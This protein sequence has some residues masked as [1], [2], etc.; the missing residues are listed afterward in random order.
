M[1]HPGREQ[2]RE[3]VERIESFFVVAGQVVTLF[4]LIG[5]GFVLAK[6]GVLRPDGVSQMSTL[7]L[8]VVTPCVMIRSFETERTP[9]MLEELGGFFLAYTLCTIL[10]I[11]LAQPLFRKEPPERRG[12]LRFGAAYGN[13]GFMGL[14]LVMSIL[15]PEAAIFGTVSA[16]SFNFLLWTHG[17][18]TMGGRVRL[19]DVFIN[20]ATVGTVVGLTLFLTGW[21]Q[22][23]PGRWAVPE[24]VNNAVSFLADL[25]TPLPMLVLGAQMAG[26]DLRSGFTDWRLYLTAA[27]RLVAAPLAALVL[28]LPLGLSPMAYCACVI[29][30]AV[31]PAG[32]TGMLAQ[33]LGRDTALAALLVS[34][35][36][37]LSVITLPFFA[38]AAQTLSGLT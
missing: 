24:A 32:A 3:D 19:R 34:V 10:G 2:R 21:W 36:T 7:A 33:K 14:P 38:V 27:V 29:L 16:V 23:A 1:T 17:L 15:G 11:L 5:V 8:Y 37:L 28:L 26:S 31:P 22:P 4:L 18:K 20:P 12:P 25:N 13:N 9:G 6:L 30:C 35:I